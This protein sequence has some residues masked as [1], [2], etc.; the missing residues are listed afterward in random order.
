MLAVAAA[1]L[2][3]L[4]AFQL[5]FGLRLVAAGD[6]Y[7]TSPFGD[8]MTNLA[9]AEAVF[10]APWGFPPLVTR[11]L[12][13][14]EP[15]SVVYT[16]SL[17]WLTLV[18]KAT[19][20]SGPANVLGLFLLISYLLQPAAMVALMRACGVTSRGALIAGALLSL[21]MPMWL[22]R[23]FGH[24]ALT[25]HWV[26]LASLALSIMAARD[27]LTWRRATTFCGLG[28]LAVGVHVYLLVTVGLTFAATLG[29]EV[30]QGRRGAWI[31][32]LAVAGGFAATLAACAILLGYGVGLGEHSAAHLGFYSMNLAS[33][34]WPYP[35]R[36]SGQ[37]WQQATGWFDGGLDATGG[38]A[39]EGLNYL[40]GGVLLLAAAA[41]VAALWRGG[42]R[43]P[44]WAKVARF[45]PLTV[46]L[47]LMTLLAVGPRAFLGPWPVWDLPIPAGPVTDALSLFRAHGRFFWACAYLIVALALAVLARRLPPPVFAALAA[48]AVAIQFYDVSIILSSV[49]ARFHAPF[50]H[51][52]PEALD[53]PQV[54]GRPWAI[55]PTY[56]CSDDGKEQWIMS[57]VV[58]LAAR[59]GGVTNTSNTARPVLKACTVPADLTRTAPAGDRRI[60]VVLDHKEKHG[61]LGT[62]EHRADCVRFR[63]GLIC[64]QGVPALLAGG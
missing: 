59:H 24:I 7:W 38:Q 53:S 33:P 47:A 46:A 37:S 51:D 36:L 14:P 16:D 43:A 29:S 1:M 50:P 2:A 55:F 20:L 32:G 56:F 15:L 58:L 17:P 60:T 25:A 57:Q 9:G 19:G 12:T 52:Y 41:I 30:A 28:A 5:M 44:S 13:W 3:G 40:G 34:V 11:T 48:A 27:G 21:L 10:R 64:G 61:R 39:F 42:L 35:S 6:A 23:Q 45:G 22:V 18:M 63:Y 62:F 49:K 26:I 8:M 54:D 4:V 31:R